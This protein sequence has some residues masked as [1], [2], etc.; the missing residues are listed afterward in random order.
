VPV[1]SKAW[2]RAMDL[3]VD[4][5]HVAAILRRLGRHRRRVEAGVPPEIGG[6]VFG[7]FP[8]AADLAHHAGLARRAVA[9]EM[10]E[11]AAGVDRL[12]A[13]LAR[14][15]DDLTGTDAAVAASLRRIG[16][17]A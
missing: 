16:D 3:D 12:R 17:G 8:S 7:A 14:L 4:T 1:V 9:E 11:L 2:E 5:D 6:A 15:R 13:D 10:A